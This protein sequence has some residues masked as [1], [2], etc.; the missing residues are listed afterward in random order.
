MSHTEAITRELVRWVEDNIHHSLKIDDLSR[1]S[2]YSR[3][4]LQ[5]LFREHQGETLGS[6]IRRRCLQRA[7]EELLGWEGVIEELALKY[8]YDSVHTFCRVFKKNFGLPPGAW[9]LRY[10]QLSE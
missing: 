1:K 3:W 10:S 7:A 8:G 4:H 6:Y 2:G 5:R 9:R